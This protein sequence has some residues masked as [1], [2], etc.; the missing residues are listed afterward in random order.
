MSRHCSCD[1][2]TQPFAFRMSTG[3]KEFYERIE[4]RL[5]HHCNRVPEFQRQ[6][7]GPCGGFV[8]GIVWY[9]SLIPA[10]YIVGCFVPQMQWSGRAARKED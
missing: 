9:K 4:W 10:E 5:R 1:R 8:S 2:I 6:Q 3:A 7:P